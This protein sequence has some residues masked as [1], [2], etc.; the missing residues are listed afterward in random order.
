M[1]TSTRPALNL[2]VPDTDLKSMFGAEG[3]KLWDK[4]TADYQFTE[5]A[6]IELLKQ[7]CLAADQIEA[8]G[9]RIKDDGLTVPTNNGGLRAHPLRIQHLQQSFLCRTLGKLGLL[10]E[11]K[12][13]GRPPNGGVGVRWSHNSR[14]A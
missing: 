12:K 8:L 5:A 2:V 7:A 10:G 14:E 1:P 6:E 9:K 4:V 11:T 13:V 3:R